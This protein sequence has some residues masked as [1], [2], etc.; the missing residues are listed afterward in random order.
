M[1]FKIINFIAPPLGIFLEDNSSAFVVFIEHVRSGAY[2]FLV[3]FFGFLDIAIDMLRDDL[4]A[5]DSVKITKIDI[6]GLKLHRVGIDNGCPLDILKIGPGVKGTEFVD[7]NHIETKLDV[8]CRDRLAIVKL[9]AFA[10]RE[11]EGLTIF[12]YLRFFR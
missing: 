9:G 10:N 5:G 12:R 7:E 6:L 3:E 11:C 4:Y 8:L 1:S 2:N